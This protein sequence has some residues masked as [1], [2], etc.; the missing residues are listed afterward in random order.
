L[1]SA[2]VTA[3]VIETYQSLQVDYAEITTRT[4]AQMSLQLAGRTSEPFSVTSQLAPDEA[5][6]PSTSSLRI[7]VL[8]F[9]SLVLSL[10][11]ALFGII[12]K[13]WLREYITWVEVAPIQAAIGLRQF[14]S[15]GLS[16]WNVP[17]FVAMI[18]ALLKTSLALFF[19]GMV[20][21]VW[22]LN[23]T[24][25]FVLTAAIGTVMTLAVGVIMMPLVSKTCPYKSPTVWP[26]LRLRSFLA[27]VLSRTLRIV[28]SSRLEGLK[29][30][31]KDIAEPARR[32]SW[33]QLDLRR[34][35]KIDAQTDRSSGCSY[36]V[37]ALHAVFSTSRADSLPV[38]AISC[39][40][41][42]VSA[43]SSCIPISHC[44]PV[45]AAA[46]GHSDPD[47]LSRAAQ[48]LSRVTPPILLRDAQLITPKLREMLAALLLESLSFQSQV[49]PHHQRQIIDSLLVLPSL[50]LPGGGMMRQC[51][52]LLSSLVHYGTSDEVVSDSTNCVPHNI[53]SV[54]VEQL[55]TIARHCRQTVPRASEWTKA[56][57][58]LN[59][60]QHRMS[61]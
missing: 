8:W 55:V 46:L 27:L 4:L 58:T 9:L 3:F 23:Q 50:I 1:F 39:L 61:N 41:E 45:V 6:N 15:E 11:A 51:I 14:R 25:A 13:Q 49:Y 56:G 43:G 33:Q 16:R 19:A 24:L 44:F 22:H 5:F 38:A 40:R 59:F 28:R 47:G 21:F 17:G 26:L 31:L 37:R 20:D 60:L 42:E 35:A 12:I 57:K 29:K 53:R 30:S 48:A 54:A 32:C 2:V 36:R 10:S 52:L 7:N 18:P 34:A